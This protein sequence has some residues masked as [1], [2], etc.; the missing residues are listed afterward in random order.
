M[1]VIDVPRKINLIPE[2]IFP[3]PPLPDTLLTLGLAAG[4]NVLAFCLPPQNPAL[5]SD[6]RT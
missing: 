5:M 6:Q 4:L 2:L 3:I 1:N